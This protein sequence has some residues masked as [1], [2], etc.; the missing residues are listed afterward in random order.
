MSKTD[1]KIVGK[2]KDGEAAAAEMMPGDLREV[3]ELIGIKFTLA[4]VERF[5]GAY[6]RVPRCE[7][8][9]RILRDNKIRAAYDDGAVSIRELARR[10]E[11]SDRRIS[12]ILNCASK[13]LPTS[14]LDA[15]KKR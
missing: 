2:N 6:I 14:I 15:M 7:N 11:M 8:F 10:Y 13:I 5:G 4:L 1:L 12:D 9:Y 3:A